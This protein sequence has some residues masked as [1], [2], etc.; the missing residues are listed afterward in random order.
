MLDWDRNGMQTGGD[1]N[2][3]HQLMHN[4]MLGSTGAGTGSDSYDDGLE[5]RRVSIKPKPSLWQRL[6]DRLDP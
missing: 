3:T 5:R 2:F 6:R 4:D 1:I